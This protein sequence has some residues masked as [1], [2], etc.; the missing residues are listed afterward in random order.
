MR[1]TPNEKSV[2]RANLDEAISSR[3]MQAV[4]HERNPNHPQLPMHVKN[5]NYHLDL[6]VGILAG[7]LDCE[8]KQ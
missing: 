1:L 6:I 7:D 5:Y 3:A 2:L 8:I 4:L